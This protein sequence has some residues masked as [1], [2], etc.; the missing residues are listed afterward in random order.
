MAETLLNVGGTGSP[1]RRF[2]TRTYTSFGPSK[3]S[4]PVHFYGCGNRGNAGSWVMTSTPIR[5]SSAV[6]WF[7]GS[8]S[9]GCPLREGRLS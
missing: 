5:A 2:V 9:L 8:S 1:L 7:F 4:C 6:G 3:D